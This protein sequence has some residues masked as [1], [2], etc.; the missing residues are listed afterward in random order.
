MRDPLIGPVAAFAAGI[1]M[2][3]LF[4]FT[5]SESIWP[6]A[7]FLGLA[8]AARTPGLRL[9]CIFLAI[10]FAGVA[11]EAWRRP[12]APPV[13]DAGPKE[14]VILGGCVVEPTVFSND[15]EQ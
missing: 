12:G 2:G 8:A 5:L 11:D 3:R 4:G 7:A 6:I 13:I 10:L 15:R 1:L 9:V 14:I